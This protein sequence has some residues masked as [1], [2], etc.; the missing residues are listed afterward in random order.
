[1]SVLNRKLFNRGGPV[2]SRGVG[3]TSGLATPKRGY[4]DRPGSYAGEEDA[5]SS[6]PTAPTFEARSF[7]DVFAER[8]ALLEKLRPPKQE[9][10]KLENAA[11]ALMTFFG[12]LMSGKSFQSGLSGALDIT[13]NAVAQATPEFSQALARKNKA[14]ADDRAE[15][16]ALDLQAFESAETAHAAE[17]KREA[18]LLETKYKKDVFKVTG[19]DGRVMNQERVS[20][21]N[22][23][24]WY[25]VGPSW[26]ANEDNFVTGSQGIYENK[27]GETILGYQVIV[28]G[29]LVTKSQD[30]NEIGGYK[31]QEFTLGDNVYGVINSNDGSFTGL[32]IDMKTKDGLE[33]YKKIMGQKEGDTVLIAGK[34]VPV[35]QLSVTKENPEFE[36]EPE[37]GENVYTV[38]DRNGKAT[39]EQVDLAAE[40]GPERYKELLA[41]PNFTLAKVSINAA[42]AD[43]LNS[44]DVGK[45]YNKDLMVSMDAQVLFV[46]DLLPAYMMTQ[47][48]DFIA[49]DTLV[50]TGF[51]W[52]NNIKANIDNFAKLYIQ[53]PENNDPIFVDALG[54][55]MQVDAD[56]FLASF[57]GSSESN[58][59]L[60]EAVASK[61]EMFNAQIIG[62]AYSLAKSNNPDG[63]ISEPDFR[64][65]LM[66][67]KGRTADPDI[68]G[69]IML[70]QYGK[71]KNRYIQSW[72]NQ[73]RID[74]IPKV[75][76]GKTWVDQAEEEWLARSEE[77]Q[78]FETQIAENDKK[79]NT[80][81]TDI[82]ATEARS[83]ELPLTWDDNG[84]EKLLIQDGK[85]AM[86]FIGQWLNSPHPNIEG[87]TWG[88]FISEY[89]FVLSYIDEEG[90][91]KLLS[92]SEKK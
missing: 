6:L 76:N 80:N 34:E 11:P 42:D 16:F 29:K 20:Y 2:S 28:D 75:V 9:F 10:N 24:T 7:E 12:N 74:N 78:I 32:Q 26:P 83:V 41:D 60:V 49:Q 36:K 89:G 5:E 56:Q 23:F 59:D 53:D 69:D 46:Q 79:D 38:Y 84:E 1:M 81:K 3:I 62:L 90:N 33:I 55:G 82:I 35:S 67:L 13:G 45:S 66:E 68:I 43:S 19:D 70:L 73:A 92:I 31:K 88:E 71:A 87:I 58:R 21:D 39:G 51:R 72:I 25:D 52:I 63:R 15:K 14:E 18:D 50:G 48:P 8:Q 77:S 57:M 4:V 17:L 65:A 91:K 64:Y 27:D 85:P 54:K 47:Q 61:G 40:N 44:M 86:M 22:G 30:G 37:L